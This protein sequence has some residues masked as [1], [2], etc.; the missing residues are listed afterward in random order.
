MAGDLLDWK[1]IYEVQC[2]SSSVNTIFFSDTSLVSSYPSFD[3]LLSC[4]TL[5]FSRP[6]TCDILPRLLFEASFSVLQLL[7]SLLSH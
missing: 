3:F 5:R 2:H 4:F 7:H 6:V 1:S